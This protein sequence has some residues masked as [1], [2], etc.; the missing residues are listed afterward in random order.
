MSWIHNHIKRE[1]PLLVLLTVCNALFAVCTVGVALVMKAMLD[2]AQ[3]GD[4]PRLL[5]AAGAFLVVLL[6][7]ILLRIAV[8]ELT[9]RVSGKLE[10][11]LK[12]GIYA[13]ILSREYAKI[14]AYHSGDLLTRLTADVTVVSDSV[15]TLLPTLVS[16]LTQ[17]IGAFAVL[18]TLDYRF[19]LLLIGVGLCLFALT[20]LFRGK[21]KR[22]HKAVQ[23]TDG[24]LRSY[25]QE[26]IENL[27][28]VQVFGVQD[29]TNEQADDLQQAHYQ[30]KLQRNRWGIAADV[31]LGTAFNLG[32]FFTLLWSG[33][34]L[35][36]GQIT[37]GTLTAMLQLVNRV[38][39]PLANLSG[40]L[41][42]YYSMLSSAERL[43]ELENLPEDA[44]KNATATEEAALRNT[45]SR[46]AVSHVDFAYGDVSVL[47]DANFS[48]E[49]GTFVAIQGI[50]GIGKST[51]FK[52]L[53]GVLS[54]QNG[55]IIIETENGT[56]LAGKDTR[57]L[58]S[59]VPQGNLLL[60]G[61]VRENICLICP[62]AKPEAIEAAL[63]LSCAEDFVQNLPQG[64]DTMLGEGGKGLSEG[65]LQRLAIARA[66]L[67]DAPV[68]LLDEATSALDEATERRLLSNLRTLKEKTCLFI[69]HKQAALD[70]CDHT[71]S[72]TDGHVQYL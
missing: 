21:F 34:R 69:S 61:T 28:A 37:F 63:R 25:L 7:E 36:A 67:S 26:T 66:L 42:R 65:Q 13:T 38:Q 46:L 4:K 5:S 47:Q 72:I 16:I 44:P 51:L 20:A 55:S 12:G 53:L 2:A 29:K 56:F 22:M 43:M 8:K 64:L 32:V 3:V 59:Y 24:R 6:L 41:P 9:V 18:F 54:P 62:D 10:M 11:R 39:V 17:S 15:T 35:A 1:I 68:L 49:K 23:E 71:L 27:L 31:G 70:I 57:N 40:L 19:A 52:L 50:S 30:A 33:L 14:G 60:S 48:I 45:F 58:F